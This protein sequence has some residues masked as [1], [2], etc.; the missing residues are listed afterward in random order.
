MMMMQEEEEA[1]QVSGIS[2][3]NVPQS[4]VLGHSLA[5]GFANISQSNES[6]VTAPGFP[7]LPAAT[8]H[9]VAHPLGSACFQLPNS[10]CVT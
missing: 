5:S 8:P 9:F 10:G 6:Q 2:V 7:D 4:A 1:V 3:S